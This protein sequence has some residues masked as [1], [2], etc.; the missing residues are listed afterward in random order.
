MKK[1]PSKVAH[2]R[3]RPFFSL[4]A[5]LPKL[6]KNRNPVPPKAPYFRTGYLDWGCA[7]LRKLWNVLLW[8]KLH[9]YIIGKSNT[10]EQINNN[11]ENQINFCELNKQSHQSGTH[12]KTEIMKL[13]PLL[14]LPIINIVLC[15][16][17]SPGCAIDSNTESYT[18]YGNSGCEKFRGGAYSYLKRFWPDS[19]WILI[20]SF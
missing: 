15:Q 18:D 14:L 20:N 2:N 13:I 9:N 10:I 12:H 3:P 17:P 16:K 11:L 5:R 1:T 8:I 7:Y 4:L 19:K 6:P